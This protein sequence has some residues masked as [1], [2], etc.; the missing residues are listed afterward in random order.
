[1]A[2]YNAP[3]IQSIGFT[4][5]HMSGDPTWQGAR[6]MYSCDLTLNSALLH[7]VFCVEESHTFLLVLGSSQNVGNDG[8]AWTFSTMFFYCRSAGS[9]QQNSPA[10]SPSWRTATATDCCRSQLV[11]AIVSSINRICAEREKVVH[12]T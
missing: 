4:D 10:L 8:A 11:V 9:L 2:S 1:M 6:P 12:T 5:E 3:A 7:K